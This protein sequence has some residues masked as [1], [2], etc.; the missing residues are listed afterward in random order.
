ML[1]L[2]LVMLSVEPLDLDMLTCSAGVEPLLICDLLFDAW[3]WLSQPFCFAACCKSHL[4]D[5]TGLD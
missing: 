2:A 4:E 5:G 1:F 3:G